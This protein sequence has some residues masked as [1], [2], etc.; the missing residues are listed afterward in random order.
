MFT[1]P[2]VIGNIRT[3]QAFF[4]TSQ[5][6]DDV[7]MNTASVLVPVRSLGLSWYAGGRFLYSGGLKGYDS[8]GQVVAEESF[9]DF[10]I[11]TGLAK[12]FQRIGLSL[13]V[14]TTLIREHVVP[15]NGSGHT[16][17]LGARYERGGHQ[18]SLAANDVGGTMSVETIEY[19]IDGEYVMGYGYT[20]NRGWG[21]LNMGA[22]VTM[23][24]SDNQLWQLGAAYHPN[25]YLTLRTGFDHS[26]EAVSQQPVSAGF[27]FLLGSLSLDYAYTPQQ[28]FS[29]THTLSVTYSFGSPDRRTVS[30]KSTANP[31][32]PGAQ[33]SDK[34]A[35]RGRNTS[36]DQQT[37]SPTAK[38]PASSRQAL[39]AQKQQSTDGR[40]A[41]A[42]TSYAVI[43]GVHS[44][45]E[46]AQAEVRA[47]HLLKIPAVVQRTGS[48][49]QVLIAKYDT[50]EE[51]QRALK[52]FRSQGHV[53]RVV[54]SS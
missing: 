44:R 14:G 52:K 12:R 3:G 30:S 31:T 11:S 7:A 34:T 42:P 51:A 28:Y 33:S 23:L 5:W 47:L 21:S 6:L 4:S 46:S 13:G 40:V 10:G 37:N 26:V 9:Y 25:A 15:E 54:R 22:Q 20:L 17:S 48:M 18:V 45:L 1:N 32:S 24:E 27:G 50:Q 35:V 16:Y 41:T 36:P 53:F 8:A 2:A 49:Y 19:G 43:A 39:T 38:A 29:N